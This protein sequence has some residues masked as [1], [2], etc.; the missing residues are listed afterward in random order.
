MIRISMATMAWVLA[1]TA[2]VSAADLVA[3]M[4]AVTAEGVDRTL[5]TVEVTDSPSGAVFTPMLAGL[6][7]GTH[8]FH[9]H[10]KG[11][12]GPGPNDK[13]EIV[14]AGAA[15]GHWDPAATGKHLG[16]EGEGH[17]GDLPALVAAADG[18]AAQPVTAPRIADVSQLAGLALMIHAGGDNHSDH[19]EPLGGGGARIACGV[20][21]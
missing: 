14:A 20:L 15:G 18:T 17:L 3:D 7:P 11:D 1:G 13:G 2:G 9:V 5:G 6:P 21:D 12:C 8:G 19:P 10:A 4:R 16:P